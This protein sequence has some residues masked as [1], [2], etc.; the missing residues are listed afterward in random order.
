VIKRLKRNLCKKSRKANLI[1]LF[2][3]PA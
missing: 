3:K 1:L 2:A